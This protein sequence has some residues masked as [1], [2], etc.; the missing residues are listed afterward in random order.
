MTGSLR[1]ASRLRL[2]EEEAVGAAVGSGTL[3]KACRLQAAHRTSSA[4]TNTTH[5]KRFKGKL[6][7]FTERLAKPAAGGRNGSATA[8]EKRDK[9]GNL[10]LLG[11]TIP[12]QGEKVKQM[13]QIGDK[14]VAQNRLPYRMP[15]T[16][17]LTRQ[18]GRGR[19]DGSLPWADNAA[20]VSPS[21]SAA[22][23]RP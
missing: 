16:R 19:G 2:R 5:K 1:A 12:R 13:A 18:Q 15:R 17:R 22:A 8:A 4:A 14:R 9:P 7:S 3:E 21:L 23:E 20:L 11:I 10:N 6:T